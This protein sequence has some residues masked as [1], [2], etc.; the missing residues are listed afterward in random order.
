MSAVH[1]GDGGRREKN[2]RLIAKPF[3][4]RIGQS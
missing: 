4:G 2:A 1:H 3:G